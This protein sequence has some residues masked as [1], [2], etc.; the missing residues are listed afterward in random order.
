MIHFVKFWSQPC[1]FVAK[2]SQILISTMH[3][4]DFIQNFR[5]MHAFCM[6]KYPYHAFC[7]YT[8]MHCIHAMH[9]MHEPWLEFVLCVG[10]SITFCV[11]RSAFQHNIPTLPNRLKNTDANLVIKLG[12]SY[13][14]TNDWYL[15]RPCISYSC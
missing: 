6:P 14:Q 15:F 10:H 8:T 12:R 3:F 13:Q 7:M 2:L 1:I 11:L 5:N 4:I 9:S